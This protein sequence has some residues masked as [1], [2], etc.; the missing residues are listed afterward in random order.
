M[1]IQVRL[2][3]SE[4]TRS[5]KGLQFIEPKASFYVGIDKN[6]YWFPEELSPWFYLSGYSKLSPEVRRRYNQLYALG[7]NE[8]FA[9]FE[10]DFVC[11][12]FKTFAKNTSLNEELRIAIAK[13]DIEEEKHARVF[14]QLN[15]AAAPEYYTD[16]DG[17]RFFAKR[18]DGIGV[19][20]LNI[21]SRF[22]NIFGVWVWIALIFEERSILYSKHYQ[23][24]RD[25]II[26]SKFKHIHHLHLIEE[27]S[28]VKLDEDLVDEFYIKL[29]WWKRQLTRFFLKRVLNS[30]RSP[31]RM[32]YAIADVLKSEFP[33]A[34]EQINRCL[35]D[36]PSL[37]INNSFQKLLFGPGAFKRTQR[38]LKT[39]PELRDL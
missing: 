15:K 27:V 21:V 29:P 18:A 3:D 2:P 34:T 9:V 12:I 33:S 30:F 8:V 23:N 35:S 11:R 4:I 1:E 7:T 26:D 20:L 13:I 6:K 36:L 37:R 25:A 24:T 16:A 22:P 32:S 17:G 19:F 39:C 28:H 31:K 5:P 14:H 10:V 38:L